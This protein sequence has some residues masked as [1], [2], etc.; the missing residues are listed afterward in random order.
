MDFDEVRY[1]FIPDENAEFTRFRAGEIDVTNTVPEQRFRE[2][3]AAKDSRL[4][5]RTTFTTFYFTLNTDRG[6]LRGKPDC[7]RRYHWRWIEM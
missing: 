6:P 4:Q 3:I 1:E 2:L 7:A 5:H